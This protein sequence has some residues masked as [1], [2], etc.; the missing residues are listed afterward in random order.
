MPTGRLFHVAEVEMAKLHAT[1]ACDR[2]WDVENVQAM[3]F[4][5]TA[6]LLDDAY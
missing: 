3:R 6:V 5:I 1:E 4:V 2:P